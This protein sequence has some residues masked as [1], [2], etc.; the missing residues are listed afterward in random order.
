VATTG[1]APE[2][3]A[4]N[5]GVIEL[6]P[7]AANPILVVSLVQAYEVVPIVLVVVKI[8]LTRLFAHTTDEIGCTTLAEGLTVILNVFDNPTQLTP[9][10][11]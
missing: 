8:E 3:I 2:L 7:E 1:I 6:L 11:V 10:L 4:V 9:P 5:D